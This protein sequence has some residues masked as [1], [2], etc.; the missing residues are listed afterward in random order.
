M[1]N[2]KNGRRA[3]AFWMVCMGLTVH[4]ADN[5]LLVPWE[6]NSQGRV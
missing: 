2:E 3:A 4:A 6:E 1:L 5:I